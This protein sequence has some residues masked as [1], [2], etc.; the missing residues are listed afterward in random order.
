MSRCQAFARVLVVH[1]LF[2]KWCFSVVFYEQLS[3]GVMIVY[4]KNA[5]FVMSK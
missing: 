1:Y 4:K 5:M 2:V 3:V